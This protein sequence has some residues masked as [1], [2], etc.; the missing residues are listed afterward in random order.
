M[1]K[2]EWLSIPNLMG[3]LRLAL[4]LVYFFLV[5][6][7]QTNKDYYVAAVIIGISMVTDFFDGKI[8]RRFHMV[9]DLGKVLDPLADKVTLGMIALSFIWRYPLMEK[10]LLLFL[11]KEGFMLVAG[12]LLMKY[13]WK[14]DGATRYGKVCTA[15]MY[16]IGF[17]LLAK[18]ELSILVVNTLLLIE[19]IV[20]VIT[21]FSYI[22]LYLQIAF[23]IRA[24]RAVQDIDWKALST[25]R[26]K[27]HKYLRRGFCFTIVCF[28]VYVVVGAI[29]PFSSA[30]KVSEVT[31]QNF[32]AEDFYSDTVG[33][34]RATIIE[35]NENALEIR[36]QMI[37]GAKESIILSTFDIRTDDA[38][39]DI[40]AALLDA[41]DRGVKVELF[42]DGFNS[43]LNMEYNPY[44]MALSTHTN[45]KII[46]YN[47]LNLLS[48]GSIMGRMHDKY[49][50][51]DNTA[52]LLGGRNTFNYFLGSYEGHENFDRDVLVYN[53]GGIDS[54]IY[55]LLTYYEEITSL[56]CCETFCEDSS[57]AWHPSVKRAKKELEVRYQE[58]TNNRP[59]LFD[60][61]YDYQG[62][63]CETNVIH[64]LKNPTHTG[65]KEPIVFEQLMRLANQA[66]ADVTIHT[67]YLICNEAMYEELI[68]L[69]SKASVMFNSAAN[70][71]NLFA[72]VD[73]MNHKED[74]IG[75]GVKVLE[76]E[77]GVS[78]HG[79]SIVIDD[80]LSII[81]TFNIDMRS[82]YI[83][84]ELMVVIDSKECNRQLRKSM[85]E[86]EKSAATVQDMNTYSS[87]PKDITRGELSTKKKI[88]H[89]L[90]GWVLDRV[91]FLL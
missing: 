3:Y 85:S 35:D 23:C 56:D 1:K 76:Y 26:K 11:I 5:V 51:V 14:T 88:V 45:G 63:T 89:Q 39:K 66:K 29:Y 87:Y 62:N 9:T 34:D 75:T 13:G 81:G 86:Y 90:F 15:T 33:S 70:N 69:G 30:P 4:A 27:R 36:L 57:L 41:C 71:G 84:T 43:W 46:L 78:Y 18:P 37:A 7:A 32:H 73:Y 50:L 64:L 44:F 60:K 49:L 52:Y 17:L 59:E 80:E 25:S 21:L 53:T 65:I 72:A 82:M 6:R 48:P 55:E 91:R 2:R 38:G 77:G 19:M 24:G 20:M 61:G 40:L 58:L 83:N 22:E 12:M 79:K 47:K 68:A 67:P 10:V 16:L 8:A 42:V 31:K 28:A 54:S 74:I